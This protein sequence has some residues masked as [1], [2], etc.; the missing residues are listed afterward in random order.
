MI[1]VSM[2]NKHGHGGV[3]SRHADIW[4]SGTRELVICGNTKGH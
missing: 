1:L 3:E 4:R 2:E